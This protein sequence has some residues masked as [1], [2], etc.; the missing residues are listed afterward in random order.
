MA[1]HHIWYQTYI[2]VNNFAYD[3]VD[4][5]GSFDMTLQRESV[6][7][8]IQQWSLINLD[9]TQSLDPLV[10]G[11]ITHNVKKKQLVDFQYKITGI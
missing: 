9:D 7:K 4:L 3:P 8:S 6:D 11:S 1:V 10:I 5:S 2:P